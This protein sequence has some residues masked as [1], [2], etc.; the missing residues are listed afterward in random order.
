MIFTPH[1]MNTR[2]EDF[3]GNN[4]RRRYMILQG[5][6]GRA[7]QIADNLQNV[8]VKNHLRC[9]NLYLGTLTR[10]ENYLNSG[11]ISTGI[12]APSIDIIL[13]ELY[14]FGAKSFIGAGTAGP[15]QLRTIEAGQIVI[16][17]GY[18]R[19]DSTTPRLVPEVFSALASRTFPAA[20]KLICK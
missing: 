18:V 16:P 8:T 4:G 9:H 12:G 5:S 13:H 1:H 7:R 10:S 15:M 2:E 20:T 14:G 17:T 19:D 3:S 6:D 11:V